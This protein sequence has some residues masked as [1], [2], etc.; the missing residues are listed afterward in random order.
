MRLFLNL[1]LGLTLLFAATQLRAEPGV[2]THEVPLAVGGRTIHVF[3]APLGTFSAAERAVGAR[4][5]VEQA[6]AL[7]GEGWTS[8]RHN[9]EGWQ[10][11]LD[12]KPLFM[13]L[14]G[15]ARP[16]A[17]ESPEELAQQA[18]HVLKTVWSEAREQG[19]P[20]ARA[21]AFLRVGLA[22]LAL[23]LAWALTLKLSAWI[24]GHLSRR[25][26][27]WTRAI[28]AKH[29]GHGMAQQL[30]A[31]AERL[32]SVLTWSLNLTLMFTY[33][34]YCLAQ[35][36]LT[37][38]TGERLANSIGG[39]MKEALT[40]MIGSLPGMVIAL[41][42]FALA[43]LVTRL[44]TAFFETIEMRRSESRRLNTHTA[45]ATR[46]IVNAALWLFAIAMAYPYLPGAHTEA[47]KGLS[48]MIG[49]MASIGASGV[50]G[51]LASGV[52]IVY[53]N[54]LRKGEYVRI[55]EHE[56]TVSEL[57]VFV[58]RLRTGLGEEI[59]L[60]NS[61]VLGNVTRN[62]SRAT[63]AGAYVLDITVTIGYDTPW[64]QVHA[65]LV[66]ATRGIP[67]VIADPPAYVVQ[68]ALS[69]F[70]VAYK[71]VAHIDS[72][73]P[74]TRAR[75]ASDLHAAIQDVFNRYDVQ[76]MSPHYCLDPKTPKRVAES[77]WFAPPAR[78][79]E[80]PQTTT[81]S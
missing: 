78:H 43:W 13:V 7:P 17:G 55:L 58:T 1:L 5:R 15:D 2:P 40:A 46:R 65:L 59:A 4:T 3:R 80:A 38:P 71:L 53:T 25:L 72:Q 68:T 14:P 18:A 20:R 30:P 61:F 27:R 42:I 49:L 28:G 45:P 66:E 34:T 64:R 47:F 8:T 26:E 10:I 16:L 69:D 23:A 79:A 51:Q 29:L 74:A 67:E 52:M 36:A 24:R 22:S 77:D 76:I 54:A 6:L 37:R 32:L 11:E 81:R 19:D 35:F 9:G 56:G 62:F 12:G 60:P 73:V 41:L 50:V 63:G 48:V 44:T 21:D 70:Y 75:V 39:M 33:I 31:F 57:G